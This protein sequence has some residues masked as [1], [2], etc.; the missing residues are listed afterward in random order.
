MV[1][2]ARYVRLHLTG[3]SQAVNCR[4][5]GLS[6]RAVQGHPICLGK[7]EPREIMIRRCTIQYN[8]L[9]EKKSGPKVNNVITKKY[10]LVVNIKDHHG[11]SS[12]KQNPSI[13]PTQS[14]PSV[15][16]ILGP[17]KWPH[18]SVCFHP[19]IPHHCH[20]RREAFQEYTPLNGKERVRPCPLG[21]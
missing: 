12:T 20:H 6:F 4:L 17:L 16:P 13:P 21:E 7:T 8:I 1:Y 14:V 15:N 19:P 3:R 10:F 5:F 11:W 2:E 9:K 18:R